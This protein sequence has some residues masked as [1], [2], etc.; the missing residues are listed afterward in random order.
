MSSAK[1]ELTILEAQLNND[2][3]MARQHYDKLKVDHASVVRSLELIEVRGSN[4]CLKR[5]PEIPIGDIDFTGTRNIQERLERIAKR[6]NG[7]VNTTKAGE[8]LIAAK[9]TSSS[10]QNIRSI[11]HRTLN[12]YTDTWAKIGAGTFRHYKWASVKEKGD[13]MSPDMLEPL[14]PE[15][16]V[17]A[18][19]R[20]S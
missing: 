7:V 1:Q 16:N 3:K 12:E 2:L 6:N 10:K 4:N 8:I 17:Q 18:A 14:D 19:I 15:S 20:S 5:E 9:Q 11:I 13:R